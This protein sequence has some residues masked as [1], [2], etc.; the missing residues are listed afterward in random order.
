MTLHMHWKKRLAAAIGAGA[1]LVTAIT[2]TGTASAAQWDS[3]LT[4]AQKQSS[5]GFFTW[6]EHTSS[7]PSLRRNAAHA[8]EVLDG[9][10][11]Y[12]KIGDKND[13]TYLTNVDIALDGQGKIN[14]FRSNQRDEPCR[15]DLP[16][17]RG[18]K[19]N[20]PSRRLIPL[21]TSPTE[22]AWAERRTNESSVTKSHVSHE[23]AA[24]YSGGTGEN[25]AFGHP[26]PLSAAQAWYGEKDEYD[27][28]GGTFTNKT[29]HYI[30]LTNP[31]YQAA[32]T[33]VSAHGMLTTGQFYVWYSYDST[34]LPIESMQSLFEAYCNTIGFD[35]NAPIEPD[36]NPEPNPEPEPDDGIYVIDDLKDIKIPYGNSTVNGFDYRNPGPYQVEDPNKI[37]APE[38]PKGYGYYMNR[39]GS[40]TTLKILSVDVSFSIT[41][42][43]VKSKPAGSSAFTDVSDSTAHHEDIAWLATNGITTGMPDGSFGVGQSVQRQDMAAFLHRL[44]DKMHA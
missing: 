25:L 7:E 9:A 34:K 32:G 19:C 39:D 28:A 31:D 29:G 23:Y 5:Y 30:N 38:L 35:L 13:A 36:P 22:L 21:L 26:T 27:A 40:K 2:T 18:R 44:H 8:V 1:I 15:T 20:D 41:Y 43:F 10:N 3:G 17:G 14:I 6:L 4:E 24:D 33:A 12:T 11:A 37:S 16:A 42:T